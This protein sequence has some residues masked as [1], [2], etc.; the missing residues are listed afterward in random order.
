MSLHTNQ[1]MNFH[2]FHQSNGFEI[3]QKKMNSKKSKSR[4]EIA[5]QHEKFKYVKQ[6]T[7]ENAPKTN[8]KLQDALCKC[9]R[10][11]VKQKNRLQRI[12]LSLANYNAISNDLTESRKMVTRENYD[13][14][15]RA[16]A[17]ECRDFVMSIF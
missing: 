1:L 10:F 6:A 8:S 12:N 5:M 7:Q 15:Q 2:N 3:Q 4:R 9:N 14:R 13:E 16:M 17:S 11:H